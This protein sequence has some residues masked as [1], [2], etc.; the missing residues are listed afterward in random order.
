MAAFQSTLPTLTAQFMASSSPGRGGAEAIRWFDVDTCSVVHFFNAWE[1]G[2]GIE[3]YAPVF[4]SMPGGLRFHAPEQAEE[5]FPHRWSIDLA[6]GQVTGERIDDL[7]GEFPRINDRRAGRQTRFLYNS[8]ARDWAFEFNFN[9]VVKYGLQSGRSEQFRYGPAETSGEHVFA[10]DPGGTAEDDG[11][12]M[13][14]VSDRESRES[15]LVVLDA[16]DV[17]AGPVARVR[18]PRRVPLG[19]HANWLAGV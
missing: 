9:G 17:A 7:S 6:A 13:T 18:I 11:W 2:N 12:L 16:R 5:P 14:I 15:A 4:D 1:Q 19:F 10:P 8:L 3:L